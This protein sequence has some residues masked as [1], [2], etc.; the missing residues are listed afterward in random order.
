M[1]EDILLILSTPKSVW[2]ALKKI[3]ISYIHDLDKHCQ[4]GI[5]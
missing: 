1:Y 2:Y 4:Q 5:G 3:I